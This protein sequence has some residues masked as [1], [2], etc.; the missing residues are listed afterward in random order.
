MQV[1]ITENFLA[2]LADIEQFLQL[3]G[4]SH[5]Y[6]ELLDDLQK[7]IISNLERHPQL[8]R[9]FLQRQP[10]SIQGLQKYEQLLA[11]PNGADIREYKHGD[12]L[13][14]YTAP[15]DAVYLLS[16]RHHKQLS[17]ELLAFWPDKKT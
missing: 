2:N 17:F 11:Q 12:Y 9:L 4:A 14:L 6:D 13:I 10:L 8:G 16:I 15:K 5:A 7:I 1:R 3:A